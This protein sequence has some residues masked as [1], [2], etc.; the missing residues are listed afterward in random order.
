MVN[1]SA[2]KAKW[3]RVKCWLFRVLVNKLL[4]KTV[5]ADLIMNPAVE[6][7]TEMAKAEKAST[8]EDD[9]RSKNS[10]KIASKKR[11]G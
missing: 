8:Q 1:L 7:A 5:D 11:Q 4:V 2:K 9:S 3:L 10:K 6:R